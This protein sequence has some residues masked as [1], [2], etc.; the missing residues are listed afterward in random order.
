MIFDK[1]I[2]IHCR[3]SLAGCEAIG[4][5]PLSSSRSEQGVPAVDPEVGASSTNFGAAEH[6]TGSQPME[7]GETSFGLSLQYAKRVLKSVLSSW[8]ETFTSGHLKA[9]FS[10]IKH[11][12]E[13]LAESEKVSLDV[14][15]ARAFVDEI[16]ALGNKWT[17]TNS[18]PN[19]D[20]FGE[21]FLKPS[22]EV[23]SK[24][25]EISRT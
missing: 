15:S 12:Q 10:M 14:T 18:F 5:V 2:F 11:V 13:I 6:D 16:I 21:M 7:H 9:G 22:S 3:L 20:F 23:K 17:E 4:E 1:I 19:G 24:L 8:I 25:D